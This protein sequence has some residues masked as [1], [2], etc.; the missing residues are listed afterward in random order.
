MYDACTID[1]YIYLL[2]FL[3]ANISTFLEMLIYVIM[4]I[5]IYIACKN[6]KS[7]LRIRK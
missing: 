2:L 7:Q 5:T 1:M 3:Y 4:Y 6:F